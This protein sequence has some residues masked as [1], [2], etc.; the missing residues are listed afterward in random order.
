MHNKGNF[1][2]TYYIDLLSATLLIYFVLCTSTAIDKFQISFATAKNAFQRQSC[3]RLVRA[4]TSSVIYI[5]TV[6]IKMKFREPYKFEKNDEENE[7]VPF[8]E[9]GKIEEEDVSV[10]EDEHPFPH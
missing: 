4:R 7:D 10:G 5:Q 6:C 9:A 3:L 1:L 2:R 8:M